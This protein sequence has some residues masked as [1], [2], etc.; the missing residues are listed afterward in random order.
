MDKKYCTAIRALRVSNQ[1]WA[2]NSIS[3]IKFLESALKKILIDKII[4]FCRTVTSLNCKL[5]E[6]GNV[7]YL[8]RKPKARHLES[9]W[10][11]LEASY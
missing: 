9:L 6:A 5:Q 7:I 10:Q 2:L 1:E 8:P 3:Q 4:I 11:Q